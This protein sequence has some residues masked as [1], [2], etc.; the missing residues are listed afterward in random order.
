MTI[1]NK[2]SLTKEKENN[3]KIKTKVQSA[4]ILLEPSKNVKLKIQKGKTPEKKSKNVGNQNMR[5]SSNSKT[6]RKIKK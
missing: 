2:N 6:N 1:S 5:I 3:I 4:K